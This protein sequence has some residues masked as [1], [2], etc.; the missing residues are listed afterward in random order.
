MNNKDAEIERLGEA[1]H[2]ADLEHQGY[3]ITIAQRDHEIAQLKRIVAAGMVLVVQIHR[4][5]LQFKQ[6]LEDALGNFEQTLQAAQQ[7]SRGGI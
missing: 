1:L 2:K 6:G 4:H 3:A 7:Y 5:N